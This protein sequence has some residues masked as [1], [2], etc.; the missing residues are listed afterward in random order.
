MIVDALVILSD[1]QRTAYELRQAG[2][3]YQAI[4]DEMGVTLEAVRQLVYRAERRIR[5]HEFYIKKQQRNLMP[6]EFPITLGE[7][8][9][10]V[11]ALHKLHLSNHGKHRISYKTSWEELRDYEDILTEQ[12]CQK[13]QSVL[14][15]IE[16]RIRPRCEKVKTEGSKKDD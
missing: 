7:L 3:T 10:I 2:K 1:R 13:A 16:E 11:E 6:V 15:E 4:A 12:L 14:K 9:I 8:K 5:S